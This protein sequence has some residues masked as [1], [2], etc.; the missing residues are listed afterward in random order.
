MSDQE[1][2]QKAYGK[3][4]EPIF[5]GGLM[6]SGTSLLRALLGQHPDLFGSFET[7][8][9]EDAIRENWADPS[10]KR[11]G[12]LRNF[13]DLD[14]PTYEKICDLK[15]ADPA[16]EYVDIVLE[17]KTQEVGKKRWVEKTPD[18]IRHWTLAK[19]IWPNAKLIHVTRNYKDCFAS[20]KDKRKD[21]I[22]TFLTSALSA[23]HD[24]DGLLG[25]ETDDYIQ[26][27]YFDLVTQTEPTM[28]KVLDFIGEDWSEACAELQLDK[29]GEEREKVKTVLGR[30][31][32]TNIS[33]SKQIF[34]D[35]IGQWERI[36]SPEEAE[37]IDRELS[38][39]ADKIG[40]KS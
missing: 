7:H 19:E 25:K 24:I 11:M 10:S 35:S 26:I 14:D 15:C 39:Y 13:F 34:P 9:Y 2:S 23:Y 18:N 33:L 40:V 5:I 29:T 31:S 3:A 8:W 6:K 36:L 32:H 37:T 30:E 38:V 4:P 20:W 16:R 12:Y 1:P 27:D 17:Y 21:T 28:R 22:E